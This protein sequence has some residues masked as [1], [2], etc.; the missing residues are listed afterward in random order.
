MVILQ[1]SK[2]YLNMPLAFRY[3]KIHLLQ[4]TGS[5]VFIGVVLTAPHPVF[6]SV[7]RFVFR[8]LETVRVTVG[9]SK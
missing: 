3:S 6:S 9:M 4:L 1:K 5:C 2:C 7:W 8:E